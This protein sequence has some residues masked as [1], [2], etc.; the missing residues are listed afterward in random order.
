MELFFVF[1]GDL[2]LLV[3]VDHAML[4]DALQ[5]GQRRVDGNGIRQDQ[6]VDLAVL[7][8]VRKTGI[9]RLPRR[10]K[11]DFLAVDLDRA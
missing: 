1:V 9:D 3:A 6:P 5:I 11:L 2:Q 7:G 10:M 8:H 4:C